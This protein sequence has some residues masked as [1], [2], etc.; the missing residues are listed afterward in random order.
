MKSVFEDRICAVFAA[1]FLFLEI[2]ANFWYNILWF[3]FTQ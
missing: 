3:D 1:Q 2:A